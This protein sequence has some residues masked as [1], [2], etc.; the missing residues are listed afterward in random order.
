MPEATKHPV[1]TLLVL[2][3]NT[4]NIL[5]SGSIGYVSDAYR[6]CCMGLPKYIF[7]LAWN[8]IGHVHKRALHDR[9]QVQLRNPTLHR[10]HTSALL[11]VW[12]A[13]C[14]M[15]QFVR[16]IL[17]IELQ[18]Q[19]GWLKPFTIIRVYTENPASSRSY[20]F[21]SKVVLSF[22]ASWHLQPLL[23]RINYSGVLP[24]RVPQMCHWYQYLPSQWT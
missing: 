11:L 8:P 20:T 4:G 1:S 18:Q 19:I 5:G 13:L 3:R 24:G 10:P 7:R 15:L 23:P 14:S 22:V 16:P 12:L 9:V 2:K 21:G 17:R 6:I